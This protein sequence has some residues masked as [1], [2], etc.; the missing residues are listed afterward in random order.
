ML[1]LCGAKTQTKNRYPSR[2]GERPSVGL[3][4]VCDSSIWL[5]SSTLGGLAIEGGFTLCNLSEH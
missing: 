1:E 4:L 2:G 5:W 3:V